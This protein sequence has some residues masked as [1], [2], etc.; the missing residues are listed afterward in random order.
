MP[1]ESQ[2]SGRLKVDT[3]GNKRLI[4]TLN[5]RPFIQQSCSIGEPGRCG[6][7]VADELEQNPAWKV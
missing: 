7:Q 2:P 1:D 4:A 6:T 3:P 5:E